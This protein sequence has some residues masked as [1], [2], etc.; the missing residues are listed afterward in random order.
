MKPDIKDELYEFFP[1]IFINRVKHAYIEGSLVI[2][3][4]YEIDHVVSEF[5]CAQIELNGSDLVIFAEIDEDYPDVY[6]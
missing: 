3:K 2:C 4:V 1:P 5:N 6:K